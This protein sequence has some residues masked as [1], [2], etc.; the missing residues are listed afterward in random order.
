[1]NE[2]KFYTFNYLTKNLDNLL[3]PSEEDY[4]EMIYR[5]Y[6]ETN[7]PIRVND[8]A[9]KLNVKP[10]SVTKMIKKLSSKNIL[11]FEKFKQI[12]LSNE[13]IEI[14]KF[15]MERHNT[16]ERFLKLLNTTVNLTYET[17]KIEHTLSNETLSKINLLIGFFENNENFLKNF[18]NFCRNH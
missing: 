8:L 9:T 6:I 14:G 3:T 11:Y 16:I 2:E 12:E 7:S 17:E 18:Y 13:G 1:M 5:I 4:I 10:P 15:L